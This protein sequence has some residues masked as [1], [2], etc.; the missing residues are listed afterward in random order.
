MEQRANLGLCAVLTGTKRLLQQ[1]HL[2]DNV[3]AM[4]I[5]MATV[6]LAIISMIAY[7]NRVKMVV[8][9]KT[10]LELIRASVLPDI[11]ATIAKP[12]LM[13]A[14]I[15]L[16]NTAESAVMKLLVIHASVLPDM[17]AT[18]AKPI[19]MTALILRVNTAESAMMKLLVI[20]ASVL[21]DMQAT[22]AKPILM[23]ALILR[24]KTMEIVTME[25]TATRVHA[26][27][28]ILA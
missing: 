10:V 7:P 25:L 5:T 3:P 27:L 16:V 24:V 11:Q 1:P 15:L 21:P 23:T 2:T 9:A 6:S 17:Q 20:R 14:L 28:D 13:T 22:T 19:L 18:I 8:H 4:H 12:I 26:L